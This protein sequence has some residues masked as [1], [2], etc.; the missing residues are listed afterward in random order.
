MPIWNYN[1]YGILNIYIYIYLN[2]YKKYIIFSE[3]YQDL[4]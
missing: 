3:Y 2:I 4:L 1:D